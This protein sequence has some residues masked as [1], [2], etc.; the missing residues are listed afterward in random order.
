VIAKTKLAGDVARLR[1]GDIDW[2]NG[3]LRV[4]GKG[5]YEVGLPLPQD[6]GADLCREP[7]EIAAVNRLQPSF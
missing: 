1:F 7:G 5:R 6:V 3:I 2:R 4:T